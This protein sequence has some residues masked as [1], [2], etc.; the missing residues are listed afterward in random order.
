MIL[1][2]TSCWIDWIRHPSRLDVAGP[3]FQEFLTCGPIIQEV[4][5]G[6]NHSPYAGQVREAML[7][8]PRRAPV[9]LPRRA[10]ARRRMVPSALAA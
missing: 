4:L 1:P 10:P 5:Q 7:A 9:R 6:L 2:D 8:I 3:R